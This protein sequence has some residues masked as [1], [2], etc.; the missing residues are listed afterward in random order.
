MKIA[1]IYY[2]LDGNSACI[3]EFIKKEHGADLFKIEVKN[4]K[5]RKGL[6][7]II[8]C[9]SLMIKKTNP[10]ILPINIDFELYDHIILGCPVWGG[11][12]ARPM[13][14]FISSTK[15]DGKKIAL[16]ASHAGS[17][18]K[19]IER[20]MSLLPGNIITGDIDIKSPLKTDKEELKQQLDTW[21]SELDL[22]Q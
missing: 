22:I 8:W 7:K 14:S 19:V 3:A 2:S 12:P 4:N 6:G 18:G 10:Q 1:V 20:L 13:L 5:E 9:F 11:E 17:A 21:I 15:I 16:Y